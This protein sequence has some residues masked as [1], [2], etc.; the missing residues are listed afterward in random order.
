MAELEQQLFASGLPVEA[1]MEK[2]ALAVARRLQQPDWWPL[3]QAM[4]ALVLVGP[5]HNGGDGLVVARELQLAGIS[6]RIWSPFERHKPLTAAHL[7]HARWLGIP[8][9][10]APPDPADPAVWIDALFGI[11]Q[12]RPPGEPLETLLEQRQQQQPQRLIAID[13]PTGLCADRGEPLGR[14]AACAGLSLSIGLIKQGFTQDSALRWLGQLERI[15]LNLPAPL[16]AG[17]SRQQPCSLLPRDLA[18][19]PWPQQDP[20]ASKYQRGRLLVI[21]GSPAYR[22]AAQ[23]CLAG[24]SASGA[25]SL[26]AVLPAVLAEQLWS[27]QPHVVLSGSLAGNSQGGLQLAG[28]HAAMLAR[29]D[30]LVLGPGLGPA[31][32]NSREE[33]RAWEQLQ[34]F[35][36]LLVLDADGLNRLAAR[37][38]SPWLQQR[39]GATWL[40]PH[41]GEFQRLF[42]ELEGLP[43]LEAAPKAAAACSGGFACSVL[44]KGARSV[45]AAA[46][47]R[48]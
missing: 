12:S 47:G 46:D 36:G 9:L 16:L 35:E 21:A 5:G 38:A 2:A 20:A 14:V 23:L 42:P 28:L 6:V 7:Q 19:G 40:T 27:V 1:L 48:R 3:L 11:G 39:R 18:S 37:N 8:Q 4:G 29:L 31:E 45:V 17:L 26:R 24:A 33:S 32:P 10:A 15:E 43:P 25:G 13:G 34:Q 30:A 41:P 22:G 44:L